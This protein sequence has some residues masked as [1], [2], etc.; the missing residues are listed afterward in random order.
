[1]VSSR[2]CNHPDKKQAAQQLRQ[3]GFMSCQSPG[4][5]KHHG[6]GDHAH[7]RL[8]LAQRVEPSQ[9]GIQ[10]QRLRLDARGSEVRGEEQGT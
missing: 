2:R 5:E 3:R 4:A 1:M 8:L 6:K 7:E 10:R 9:Q